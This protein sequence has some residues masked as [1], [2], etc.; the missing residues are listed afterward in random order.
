[1]I[2]ARMLA[3]LLLVC[4][5]AASVAVSAAP[6]AAAELTTEGY[7]LRLVQATRTAWPELARYNQTTRVFARIQLLAS[8]GRRAWVMDAQGGREVEMA[9]V[10]DLGVSYEYQRYRKLLWRGRPAI[11]IGLG[12]APP[13]S[14][15]QRLK[16]PLAVPELFSLA[17][18]E[19]FH[20]YR[21]CRAE[22]LS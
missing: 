2:I 5:A 7:V 22:A 20:F 4:L 13:A 1:M 14:E 16:D 11:F 15:R 8:D 3:L 12:E 6:S 18:H 9:K 21:Q 17:T 10:R 19:A